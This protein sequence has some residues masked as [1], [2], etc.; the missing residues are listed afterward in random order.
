MDRSLA[1]NFNPNFQTTAKMNTF[2]ESGFTFS[3]KEKMKLFINLLKMKNLFFLSLL[4]ALFAC[5][6]ISDKTYY[7]YD[8]S[9]NKYI[10]TADQLKFEPVNEDHSSSGYY[11]GGNPKTISVSPQE[12][13]DIIN[14]FNA[15][16][17]KPE[18]QTNRRKKG[19]GI[20]TIEDGDHKE[21]VMIHYKSQEQKAIEA[22]LRSM[23]D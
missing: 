2:M 5:T 17:S 8:G 6:H 7:Y 20:I 16:L 21:R 15:A 18:I 9:N 23:V 4:I 12:H 3:R 11:N 19:S 13:R 14:L 22:A 10:L 1:N